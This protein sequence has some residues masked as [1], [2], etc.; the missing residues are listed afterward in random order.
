MDAI[1]TVRAAQGYVRLSLW[2]FALFLGLSLLFGGGTVLSPEINETLAYAD[3]RK[4]M[5]IGYAIPALALLLSGLYLCGRSNAT[6]RLGALVAGPLMN[7][8]QSDWQGAFRP[9]NPLWLLVF[10]PAI[11]IAVVYVV[12][13]YA[14]DSG[15]F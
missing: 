7:E 10:Y 1:E 5:A 13:I 8:A 6:L 12:L 14:V 15:L 9:L 4:V 2:N 11:L 3:I